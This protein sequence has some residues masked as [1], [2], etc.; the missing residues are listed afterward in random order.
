VPLYFYADI[1]G[2]GIHRGDLFGQL[3]LAGHGVGFTEADVAEFEAAETEAETHHGRLPLQGNPIR[4]VTIVDVPCV[5]DCNT[6]GQ[7]TIDEVLTLVNI[8]LGSAEAA[9]C[10]HGV[11]NG[12]EVDVALIL[13]AVNNAL[14]ACG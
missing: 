8:A 5:G 7:V 1:A 10:P 13:H 3:T 12:A 6:D 9:A 4:H 2:V 11:P 14:N